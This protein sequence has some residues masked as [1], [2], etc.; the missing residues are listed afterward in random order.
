MFGSKQQRIES[1]NRE[2]ARNNEEKQRGDE[3]PQL[4]IESKIKTLS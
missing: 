2:F 1:Q 4:K 3:K